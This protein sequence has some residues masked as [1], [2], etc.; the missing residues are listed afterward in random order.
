MSLVIVSGCGMSFGSQEQVGTGNLCETKQEKARH[1]AL[2]TTAL[3]GGTVN[4]PR[5]P[6]PANAPRYKSRDC[7]WLHS[8]HP[9][10]N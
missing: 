9:S 8:R 10:I 3:P 6:T 7:D 2:R 5:K 1:R 4:A